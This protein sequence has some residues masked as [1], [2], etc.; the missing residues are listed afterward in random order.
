MTGKIISHYRVLEKLG[1]GGM[2]T[3][4]KG[5]DLKLK[6]PVA[7]KFLLPSFAANDSAKARFL[8]EAQAAATLEHPNICPVYGMEDED[9]VLCIVM[10]LVDGSS[11]QAKM[12]A[13]MPLADAL[14]YTI[15]I[16]EGLRYAHD[17]GVIHRDIKAANILLSLDGVARIT[18][19]G[20]ALLENRSRLTQRGT[21][22]GT[23][24]VMA[25]EQV[26]AADAD[27]RTDIWALGV[28]LYELLTGRQPF[29]RADSDQTMH[30]ILHE[31][32]PEVTSVVPGLPADLSWILDKTLSKSR[33]ERYQYV[34][35]LVTD[36][37]AVVSRLSLEQQA[38]VVGASGQASQEVT[39][40]IAPKPPLIRPG[41]VGWP[42]TIA[43]VLLFVAIVYFLVRMTH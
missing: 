14:K 31:R 23:I 40:T 15:E 12:R 20:L 32:A 34:D 35:D 5:E 13:G 37:R 41:G 9:G 16:G 42:L 2:G 29:V 7:L 38:M 43:T 10:A 27:R 4:Y 18:D 24:N 28:L 8:R 25:P 33:S 1:E 26:M 6:R 17:H 19:F 21:L 11:F 36:L 39:K 3:V 22:L 30:A